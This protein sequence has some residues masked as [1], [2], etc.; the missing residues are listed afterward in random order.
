MID[1]KGN[2]HNDWG[3]WYFR[4]ERTISYYCLGI[5]LSV[6]RVHWLLLSYVCE[7]LSHHV[8]F[9]AAPSF[10][11]AVF[12]PMG[13]GCRALMHTCASH[14]IWHLLI[15]Q[16]TLWSEHLSLLYSQGNWVTDLLEDRPSASHLSTCNAS[17]GLCQA[18]RS[19]AVIVRSQEEPA[20]GCE[21]VS[22]L[23]L[24][25]FLT[26]GRQITWPITG[27]VGADLVSLDVSLRMLRG[28]SQY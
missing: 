7:T 13:T 10:C 2:R 23:M 21:A 14:V 28:T 11:E 20:R 12:R 8:I 4:S 19:E 6:Q 9:S 27:G 24:R 22:S 26:S 5:F 18:M 3:I 16:M 15:L 17:P 1:K 25:L